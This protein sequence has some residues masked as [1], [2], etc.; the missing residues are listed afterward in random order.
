MA[1]NAP[2]INKDALFT[3]VQQYEGRDIREEIYQELR[4]SETPWLWLKHG[5]L[6]NVC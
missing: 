1:Q 4:P 6:D 5:E 3:H 2:K